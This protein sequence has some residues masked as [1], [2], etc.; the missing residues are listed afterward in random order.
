M[1][2]VDVLSVLEAFADEGALA[3]GAASL[4]AD[5]LREGLTRRGEASFAASG[6]RTPVTTYEVLSGAALAW[7]AVTVVP[8]DE[9]WVPPS[10]PDS[11]EGLLRRHLLRD[12]ASG[13]R[14]LPLWSGKDV[15]EAAAA[16][17]DLAVSALTP[18]DAV[19]LGMGEDG[20][21]ASL[22]PHS[23]ALAQ[24]LDPDSDRFCVAVPAAKPAPALPRLSLTARAL[25]DA[26]LIVLLVTGEAKR[27]TLQAALKGAD[28]PVRRVLVQDRA[29]VRILWAP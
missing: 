4:V 5:R 27:R 2:D 21:L 8:T 10:S 24:G 29:P 15:L 3:R 6:G 26:R 16:C 1:S 17:G 25:L 14:L 22:F 18:F 9:R 23:P 13:A 19:L 28:L 12:K 11:N 20:H 7:E